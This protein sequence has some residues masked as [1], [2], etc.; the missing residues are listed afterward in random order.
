MKPCSLLFLIPIL[1]LTA[2]SPSAQQ[3]ATMTAS[4]WTLTPTKT[5]TPTSTATIIPSPT[6]TQTET[7]TP[8][9][10]ATPT[11]IPTHT[12]TPTLAAALKRYSAPDNSFSFVPPDGWQ[13][14]KA[15]ADYPI[16]TGPKIGNF[17]P[18]LTFAQNKSPFPVEFYAAT[19]QDGLKRRLPNLSQISEDFLTTE[20][21]NGYFRWEVT[22]TQQGVRYHQVFYFYESGDWKLIITYT[23]RDDQGSQYD[24][25]IDAAMKTVQFSR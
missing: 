16:L 14:K 23:R 15:G 10:T 4:V 22:T 21:G 24:P 3:Q 13:A 2:C 1:W 11:Q 20:E 7:P 19:Y 17:S 5:A 12:P 25:Q 6:P 18:V 9:S 8:T